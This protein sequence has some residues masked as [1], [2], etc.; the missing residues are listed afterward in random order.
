[1]KKDQGGFGSNLLARLDRFGLAA[2]KPKKG[3]VVGSDQADEVVPSFDAGEE[4]SSAEPMLLAAASSA[5][6][7]AGVGRTPA[8]SGSGAPPA[9]GGAEAG[10]AAGGAAGGT[11]G[12]AGW[13]VPTWAWIGGGVAVA[14]VAAGGGGGGGGGGGSSPPPSDTTAPAAPAVDLLASSDTG[15]SAIDNKTGDA[16]PTFRITLAGTGAAAPVAGNAVK[17]F[18][19]VTQVGSAT[20]SSAD[21]T[22]GYVDVTTSTLSAGSLSIT[23]TVTDAANNV[24]SASA[25]LA[26]TLDATAPT[27]AAATMSGASVILTYTETGAGLA[28]T[29]P[30][31]A[32]FVVLKNGATQTVTNVAVDQVSERVTLSLGVGNA[33]G[34]SG[35]RV[36][37]GHLEHR[38]QDQRHDADDSRR[39]RKNRGDGVGRRR[40]GQA[41]PV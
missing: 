24:S 21:V 8:G 20:L 40:R 16:T 38:R 13:A 32:D 9:A 35:H 5:K 31:A 3:P 2:Q 30:A 1:M 36:G 23:A 18:Q 12:V 29:T 7:P 4:A 19:G 11:A 28:S 6:R 39:A 10:G 41:V 14:A 22:N 26:V 34:G 15:T 37:H 17:L 27:L 33:V 25:A